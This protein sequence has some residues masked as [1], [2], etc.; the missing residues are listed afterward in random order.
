MRALIVITVTLLVA[1]PAAAA[2]TSSAAVLGADGEIYQVVEGRYADLFPDGAETAAD[3]PVLA[4]DVLQP[5]KTPRRLLVPG[6]DGY[7]FERQASA[8]YE[9]SSNTVFLMWE[10]RVN[11]IHSLLQLG[12]LSPTGWGDTI[13]LSGNPFG[14][15]SNPRFSVSRETYA[16]FD[17]HGMSRST[18]TVF[19]LMWWEQGSPIDQVMYSPI[20]LEEGHYP[21][22]NRVYRLRD[23][24]QLEDIEDSAPADA[25]LAAP[26][27]VPGIDDRTIVMAFADADS[28]SLVTVQVAVLSKELTNLADSARAHIVHV[29]ATSLLNLEVI[30]DEARAHIVQVGAH[31]HPDLVDLLAA[32]ARNY[33][34]QVGP[35]YGGGLIA[36]ADAARAHIVH[37]GA[38]LDREG[39]S[40]VHR[41]T[42]SQVL[43]VPLS[44]GS[45]DDSVGAHYFEVRLVSQRPIPVTGNDEVFVYLSRN[46]EDLIVAWDE[47][48]SV[49]YRESRGS[50]WSETLRLELGS[51]LT[52]SEAH[53]ILDRRLGD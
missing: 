53:R 10:S 27:L 12:S 28:G 26:A 22:N 36:L 9:Q 20:V 13:E 21:G 43:E 37:V 47:E 6:T 3:A 44:V 38:R 40:V 18:R 4:L 33:I 50:E 35:S 51:Q 24:F 48:N 1:L 7:E 41:D 19:H 39:L 16:T 15:K 17:D 32:A 8:L 23:F 14:F 52:R 49:G 42:R 5:G 31:L 2:P 30:A 25:L 46:G 29:G 34:L 45:A 11:G